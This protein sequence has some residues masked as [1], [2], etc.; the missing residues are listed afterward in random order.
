[1]TTHIGIGFSQDTDPAKAAEEA[2]RE[3]ITNLGKNQIDIALVL[4]TLH[5]PP[6]ETLPILR[7]FLGQT[8]VIGSSTAGIILSQS[9]RQ[10]GM[11]VLTITSEDIKFGI[12]FVDNI[13]SRNTRQAGTILAQS[14]LNDFGKHGRQIF[15]FFVDNHVQNT[16]LLIKSIQEVLGNVFP[17]VGAQSCDDFHFGETFQIFRDKIFTN[18]AAGLLMGGHLSVGVGGQ[19]G[20][21]PLGKPRIINEA[22]GNII[23]TIDGKKAADLYKEYFGQEAED[24]HLNQ[25]GRIAILYPLG[26][27]IEGSQEYL[28]RNAVAIQKDGSIVCQGDVPAGAEVHIMIGNKDSCRHAALEAALEAQKNLLGKQP[29]LIIIFESMARLKLLG[30]MAFQEIQKIKEVFGPSVP[31][32]GMYSQGEVYPLQS[33]ERFKR[34]HLQNES[35]VILAIS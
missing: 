27:S 30:R 9:I 10:R 28:L 26:F 4:S 19:H 33:I 15:L 5:Y 13:S 34:P 1:M 35:I 6:A 32:I 3:A 18:S 22:S 24:L 29:R 16:S 7:D 14:T 17:V 2:A 31:L 11:A 8:K 21:R 20:W 25:L 12:G 23:K